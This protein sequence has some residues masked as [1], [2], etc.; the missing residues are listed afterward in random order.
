MKYLTPR[1]KL[2]FAIVGFLILALI[3]R[4]APKPTPPAAPQII[5]PT[6]ASVK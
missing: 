4:Y 6:M 1:S 5:M 2:I 3:S